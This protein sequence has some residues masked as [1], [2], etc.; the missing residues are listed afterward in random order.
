MQVLRKIFG[1][2]AT[3]F[4]YCISSRN[5]SLF[6]RYV[7]FRCLC[8]RSSSI[9]CC[10]IMD[11]Y[12]IFYG[13]IYYGFYLWKC[14]ESLGYYL[15]GAPTFLSWRNIS[16]RIIKQILSNYQSF[17]AFYLCN[18][19]YERGSVRSGFTSISS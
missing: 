1:E 14:R 12:G 2:V 5:G 9:F 4:D 11:C 16:Y 10:C 13:C 19:C 8:C 7:A 3:L 6:M 15:F 17:S 18:S